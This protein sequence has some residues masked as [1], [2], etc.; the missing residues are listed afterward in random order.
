[1]SEPV[2]SVVTT[3]Y[4]S[5]RH[6][7]AFL[8]EVRSV[9]AEIDCPS[10][11]II[12]DDGSQDE[13]VEICLAQLENRPELTLVELS[14][15]F[16]QEAAT[17]EALKRAKGQFVFLL[18][19]DLE[20]PPQTLFE[21]LAVMREE[22]PRVDLVYGVQTRR[23]G[24]IYHTFLG[25]LFYSVVNRFSDVEIPRDAM[26]IRLMTR[27][28]L[29]ALLMHTERTLALTGLFVLTGFEQ[30]AIRV[31]K[32]Y[33]GY[34]SYN[35][36]KRLSLL[37]RYMLIFSWKPAIAITF[38]GFFAALL[39]AFFGIYAVT[40]YF[41]T[42]ETVPGWASLLTVTVFFD[43]ILLISVGTCAAYLAFIFQEVKARP[44]AIVKSVS[45]RGSTL[46]EP[47]PIPFTR[48]TQN[49]STEHATVVV[50]QRARGTSAEVE[51]IQG[52][53]RT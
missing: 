51:E 36:K 17:L 10:E 3:V 29:D 31:N 12:V 40:I 4:N 2:L 13:T 43:G 24:T 46:F 26:P 21:M 16:G 15:N 25:S 42:S 19:S 6:V 53:E 38:L 1:M 23:S 44:V 47:P 32:V 34:S 7:V 20:E 28:Y 52:R 30:R 18:D 8:D 9:L 22:W 11:I 39:A 5:A 35:L 48:I 41:T 14:R 27:R 33:K 50:R 49:A 45:K 37:F